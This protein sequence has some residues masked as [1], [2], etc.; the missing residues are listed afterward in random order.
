MLVNQYAT[1]DAA[2]MSYIVPTIY[3]WFL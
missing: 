3:H 2:S 1:I